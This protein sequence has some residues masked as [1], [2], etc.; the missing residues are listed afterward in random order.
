MGKAGFYMCWTGQVNIRDVFSK[1]FLLQTLKLCRPSLTTLNTQ[2]ILFWSL[3]Y[4]GYY[5]FYL[6]IV[7]MLHYFKENQR[8]KNQIM[9]YT[10]GWYFA[11]SL[12]S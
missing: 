12:Y 5:K 1:M 11:I 4:I 3:K 9:F 8:T 10:T 6:E 2:K 7:C